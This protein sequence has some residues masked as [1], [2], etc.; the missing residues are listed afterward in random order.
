MPKA[1]IVDD[2][3]RIREL[4][5]E[6][7]AMYEV[8]FLTASDGVEALEIINSG[9]KLD[10]II[11]DKRMPRKNGIDVLREIKNSGKAIPVILLSG[12]LNLD[13]SHKEELRTLGFKPENILQKPVNLTILWELIQ[14][15]L[16]ESHNV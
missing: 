15:K 7:L 12:E 11:L 3:E 2:E 16:L 1:L 10:I 13:D 5:K 14:K 8:D 4:L 6:L 9:E